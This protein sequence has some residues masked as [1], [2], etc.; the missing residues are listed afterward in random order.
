MKNKY[1]CPIV[2]IDKLWALVGEEVRGMSPCMR[3]PCWVMC[4]ACVQSSSL[5]MSWRFHLPSDGLHHLKNA[6]DN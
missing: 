2:N 5:L 3:G 4:H 1:H 6:V